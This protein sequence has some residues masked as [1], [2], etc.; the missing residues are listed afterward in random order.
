MFKLTQKAFNQRAIQSQENWSG[1]FS[2]WHNR[3]RSYIPH[4]DNI[5]NFQTISP[6]SCISPQK[7]HVGGSW[8]CFKLHT[9][10][11]LDFDM[12][13]K[14]ML[15]DIPTD[16]TYEYILCSFSCKT[17]KKI[18]TSYI[19]YNVVTVTVDRTM[20]AVFWRVRTTFPQLSNGVIMTKV[21][22]SI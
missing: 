2:C 8:Y 20:Y 1:F 16:T 19:F 5:V 13:V 12:A 22:P 7:T 17:I 9:S 15:Y 6:D 14:Q 11:Q 3:H 21:I 18:S 4:I 10:R